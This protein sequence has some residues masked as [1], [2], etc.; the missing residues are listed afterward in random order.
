MKRLFVGCLLVFAW[1]GAVFGQSW[2]ALYDVVG[3]SQNDV[4][5]IRQRPDAAA[6][7]TGALAPIANNIEVIRT[8]PSGRWGLVNS[9]EGSGWVSLTYMSRRANQSRGQIPP[10][11]TCYGTEPFWTLGRENA[12]LRFSLSGEPILRTPDIGWMRSSNRTDRFS[13][14]SDN[15]TVLLIVESCNDGMSDRE[16]GL[17]VDL[18]VPQDGNVTHFSGCCTIQP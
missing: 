9:G 18:L 5:N 17:A 15:I 8:D 14:R 12:G 1:A 13:L 6:P 2:P 10:V 4:L 7:I 11:T 16:F 3:V